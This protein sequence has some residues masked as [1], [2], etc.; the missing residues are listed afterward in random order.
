MNKASENDFGLTV[1]VKG[2]IRKYEFPDKETGELI[3]L[4]KCEYFGGAC[5][6]NLSPEKMAHLDDGSF[7]HFEGPASV[8]PKGVRITRVTLARQITVADTGEAD[9]ELL[10]AK[11]TAAKA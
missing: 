4:L 9:L 5:S 3:K 8:G 7:W 1:S 11:A 2:A 6:I 10:G